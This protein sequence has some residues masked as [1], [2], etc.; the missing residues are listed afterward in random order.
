MSKAS[1]GTK[2]KP[3]CEVTFRCGKLKYYNNPICRYVA[4]CGRLSHGGLRCRKTVNNYALDNPLSEQRGRPIP[5]LAAWIAHCPDHCTSSQAHVL[6]FEP[7]AEDI[8]AIRVEVD[9]Y[10]T[11]YPEWEGI[12]G[13]EA[14]P[15]RKGRTMVKRATVCRHFL[16]GVTCNPMQMSGGCFFGMRVQ[17]A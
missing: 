14:P 4:E 9:G 6:L 17:R 11:L 5:W 8:E 2:K 16:V 13:I 1:T 3:T 12:L 15:S 7:Q 10:R